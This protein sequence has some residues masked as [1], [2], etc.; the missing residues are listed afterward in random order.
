MEKGIIK[1]GKK[2]IVNESIKNKNELVKRLKSITKS[3]QGITETKYE[4]LNQKKKFSILDK[5]KI[6]N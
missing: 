1:R 6:S 2:N 4:I 5:N 3:V